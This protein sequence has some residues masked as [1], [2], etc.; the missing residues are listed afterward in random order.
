MQR[1]CRQR[2]WKNARQ[3]SFDFMVWTKHSQIVMSTQEILVEEIK[4]Q[5]EPVLREVLHYLKFL[6]RQRA[7]EAWADIL[8]TREVEQEV[9]NILDGK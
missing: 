7:E 2:K 5:P 4:K 8:P 1:E 6:E 9:L 3:S